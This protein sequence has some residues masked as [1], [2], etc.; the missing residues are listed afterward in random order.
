MFWNEDSAI[1]GHEKLSTDICDMKLQNS[2]EAK[3][4]QARGS[5]LGDTAGFPTLFDH[6]N[7]FLFSLLIEPGH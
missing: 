1:Y 7:F 6:R 2:T 5:R 4:L 3:L